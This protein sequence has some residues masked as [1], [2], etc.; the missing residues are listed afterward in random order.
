MTFVSIAPLVVLIGTCLAIVFITCRPS[1]KC[2][3]Y[4]PASVSLL[5]LL[6]SIFTIAKEGSLGFWSVHT[7]SLWGNQV[8]FDLLLMA[9]SAWS[10]LVARASRLKMH[11]PVW[12]F[13]LLSTGSVGILLMLS[14]VC[15]LEA[16]LSI[17]K[18]P[19]QS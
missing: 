17:G 4:V 9:G 13:L 1:F 11:L 19:G 7:S 8:W 10:L 16:K 3:W 5:F 2:P 14:R 6:F 12:L 15:Y 18:E